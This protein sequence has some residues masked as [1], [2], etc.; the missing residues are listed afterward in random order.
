[1][2]PTSNLEQIA[3]RIAALPEDELKSA[4][5]DVMRVLAPRSRGRDVVMVIA[6]YGRAFT[7]RV[8]S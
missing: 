7:G 2:S 3:A 4:I 6:L 8:R 5:G 1:M